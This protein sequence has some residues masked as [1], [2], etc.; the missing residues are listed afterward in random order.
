VKTVTLTDPDAGN[1]ATSVVIGG[2]VFLNT[3]PWAVNKNG[4][5]VTP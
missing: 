1:I 5:L 2:D 4:K 3:Q